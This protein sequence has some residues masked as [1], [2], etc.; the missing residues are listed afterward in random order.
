MNEKEIFITVWTTRLE[1]ISELFSLK[2]ERISLL[3]KV[4]TF[5]FFIFFIFIKKVKF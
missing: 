4:G 3:K 1:Y 5:F 2:N